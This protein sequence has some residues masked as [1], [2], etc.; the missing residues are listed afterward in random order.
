MRDH[1]SIRAD[2]FFFV[3]LFLFPGFMMVPCLIALNTCREFRKLL[4]LLLLLLLLVFC[5][6]GFS[7]AVWSEHENSGS[8]MVEG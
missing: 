8:F 6:C 4:L 5:S 1:V 7:L 3:V 2:V